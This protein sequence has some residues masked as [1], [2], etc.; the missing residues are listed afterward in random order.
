MFPKN[1]SSNRGFSLI[2]LMIVVAIIG[3][4]AAVAIPNF[5]RFQAKAKQS[6]AKSNLSA[7]YSASKA[8]HAE[9]QLYRGVFMQIG[10]AP[11]GDLRYETGFGGVGPALPANFP[12][13]LN[14]FVAT[15][16]QA[17]CPGEGGGACQVIV[18]P[19]A[20]VLPAAAAPTSTTFQAVAG[21]DLDGDN[22]RQDQWMIDETKSLRNTTSDLL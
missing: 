1:L 13:D 4:L 17:Y 5:Q 21:G 2:E 14:A 19:I 7:M 20:P 18:A 16:T 12:N 22:A 11:E 3:V 10:F 15:N 9:W 8:F 6:E